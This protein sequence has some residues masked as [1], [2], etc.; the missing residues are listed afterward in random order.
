[1][2]KDAIEEAI[3]SPDKDEESINVNGKRSSQRSFLLQKDCNSTM[4]ADEG[5]NTNGALK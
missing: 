1:M 3:I 5:N 2:L 4:K